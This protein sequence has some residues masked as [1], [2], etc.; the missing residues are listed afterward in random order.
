[1]TAPIRPP[2]VGGLRT[3]APE[4]TKI[5]EALARAV[6]ERDYQAAKDNQKSHDDAALRNIRQV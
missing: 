2:H 3:L 6:E 4:L 5:V 1:M